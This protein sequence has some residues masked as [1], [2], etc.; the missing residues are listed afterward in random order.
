MIKY[1]TFP[2]DNIC[3]A[4]SPMSIGHWAYVIKI[5]F[6]DN[7]NVI[8]KDLYVW[9]HGCM[10]A[11][12]SFIILQSVLRTP[13]VLDPTFLIVGCAVNFYYK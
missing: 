2:R 11:T 12:R 13:R 1:L 10:G 8:L 3:A 5:F 7:K 9:V 6:A 4:R